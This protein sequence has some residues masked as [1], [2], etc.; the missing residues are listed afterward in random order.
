MPCALSPCVRMQARR[1]SVHAGWQAEAQAGDGRPRPRRLRGVRARPHRYG[2]IRPALTAPARPHKVR[3]SMYAACISPECVL[4]CVSF[5]KHI[6]R[7]SRAG[8]AHTI[9]GR[10]KPRAPEQLPGPQDY[11]QVL[12]PGR[13]GPAF[14]IGGRCVRVNDAWV[15]V[16]RRAGVAQ[17][18]GGGVRALWA[19]RGRM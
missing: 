4:V 19:A 13:E 10:P 5:K 16:I 18:Y 17:G 14:T 6:P 3:R 11:Q 12:S 2:C 7:N 9:A 15:C 8:P 1:A